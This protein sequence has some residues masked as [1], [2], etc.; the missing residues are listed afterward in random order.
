MAKRNIHWQRKVKCNNQ[1][2]LGLKLMISHG[3]KHLIQ[4]DQV[5]QICTF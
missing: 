3:L 4:I 2:V 5:Q 1:S